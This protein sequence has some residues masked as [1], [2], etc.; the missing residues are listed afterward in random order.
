V[1]RVGGT[2]I[3][4]RIDRRT[5]VRKGPTVVLLSGL[6]TPLR[7]WDKM[8]TDLAATRPSSRTTAAAWTAP[9]R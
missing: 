3:Q 8:R 5:G 2:T 9:G 4:A 1:L 6:D 7:V